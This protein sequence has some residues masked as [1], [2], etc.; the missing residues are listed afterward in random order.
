VEILDDRSKQ[1]ERVEAAA[2]D[3]ASMDAIGSRMG[4]ARA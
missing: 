1:Q 2:R 4:F 3:Q